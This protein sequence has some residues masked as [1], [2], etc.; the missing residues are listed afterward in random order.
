MSQPSPLL[1]L[2]MHRS[3]TSCLTGL[4]EEAGV[5]LGEVRR[6]SAHNAK[7]NRENPEIMA[8]NEAVLK[9]NG[10]SWDKPPERHV[11]WDTSHLAERDRILAGYPAGRVWGLKDPRT[12]FTLEGWRAALPK[13]RLIGTVRHPLAV[14]RSLEARSKM[15]LHQGLALWTSYNLRLL[16]LARREDIPILS[17]DHSAKRYLGAAAAL[18]VAMGLN[19]PPNGIG[20]FDESLRHQVVTDDLPLPTDTAA[21]YSALQEQIAV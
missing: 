7:G 1:V 18:I 8:L 20:F 11:I 12:L 15:P 14:A 4:L 9:A 2:G 21:L 6:S 5:W 16:E 3:G 19:V 10:A 17:F 13:A